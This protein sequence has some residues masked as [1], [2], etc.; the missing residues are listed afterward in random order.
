[1]P[2][3]PTLDPTALAIL[4][5]CQRRGSLSAQ[6]LEQLLS[7]GPLLT[8]TL[9]QLIDTQ[10]L[11]CRKDRYQ[12]TPNGQAHLDTILE[13]L[14][15][16]LAPDSTAYQK[17]YQ[18][19]TPTLPFEANTTWAE[20]LCINYQVDPEALR[21]LI[22]DVFDL[23]LFEGQGFVSLVASRLKDFGVSRIPRA[24]RMNFYQATYRAHVTYTDFRQRTVRGCFFLRSE[25]NSPLMS[26]V[27]NSM[28]E[29][30]HHHCSTHPIF[31]ARNGEDLVFS[32]DSGEDPEGKVVLVLDLSRELPG[33][34]ASSLFPSVES[35]DQFLVDFYDAFAYEPETHEVLYLRL[36][37]GDWNIRIFEPV[38]AYLGFFS[39]GP[40]PPES[41]RLDSVFYFTDVPYRWLPLV[42][43]RV[44]IDKK[45]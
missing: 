8:G 25:T 37:R 19:E 14:E 24:L 5:A 23:D 35:A 30:R 13:N 17:R 29:F 9:Q 42:R 31:M 44:K 28:P 22:P 3:E 43:E 1:M 7:E 27:A 36:D 45:P 32:V 26:M 38:D 39:E 2:E 4:I 34:P 15:R 10:H 21:P 12:L 6:E 11:E 33:M 40:F 18:R 20:A 41:S 16:E